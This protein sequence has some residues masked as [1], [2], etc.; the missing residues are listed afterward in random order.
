MTKG[1]A[2]PFSRLLQLVALHGPYEATLEPDEAERA[3]IARLGSLHSV[4][5]FKA[6]VLVTPRADG[7]IR[8]TGVLKAA[9][10]PVCVVSLEPFAQ[11][12]D[13]EIEAVFAEPDV[14]T[15]LEK[16]AA[17]AELEFDPPDEIEGGIIDIG[18]LAVEFL[19]LALDPYPKKPG[20]T[21]TEHREAEARESPFAALAKLKSL[22]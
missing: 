7:T 21:F 8:V 15:R 9:V 13:E 14:I 18:A 5:A 2:L 16:R 4:H 11:A 10:E 22:D 20:A 12:I 1:D 6:R 19:M 3:A 17:E